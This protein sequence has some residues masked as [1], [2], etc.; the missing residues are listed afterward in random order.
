MKSIQPNKRLLTGQARPYAVIALAA[1]SVMALQLLEPGYYHLFMEDALYTPRYITQFKEAFGQGILYPRWMP[2]CF[3]G[4]G[5]PV[6]DYYSPLLYFL[7]ALLS[8]AGLS[9][10]MSVTSL[11]LLGLFVGGVFV[12][13]MIRDR[14]SDRAAL[15]AALL[16]ISLPT[17]V[18]D[19]YFI[20]TPAGRFSEVWMPMALFFTGRLVEGPFRRKYFAFAA[21]SYAALILS[22]ITTAYLF[23]PFLVAYGLFGVHPGYYKRSAARLALVIGTGL[24][25]SAVFFVP[26]IFESQYAQLGLLRSLD[27][28]SDWRKPILGLIDTPVSPDTRHLWSALRDSILVEAGGVAALLYILRRHKVFHLDRGASFFA[29]SLA[30]CI[31]MMSALSGLLWKHLPGFSLINFPSRYTVIYMLFLAALSG[32]VVD[33]YISWEGRPKA[34]G[35]AFLLILLCL[36]VYDVVLIKKSPPPVTETQALDNANQKDMF[37]Y[38]PKWASLPTCLKL[39]K[40]DPLFSSTDRF[41]ITVANWGY[42]DRRF[43]VDSPYGVR[44]R[45]K[46]FYFPGWK[47]WVDGR[48]TSISPEDKTGAI[49]LSIPAGTHSVQLKFVDTPPR[50]WGKAISLVTLLALVFPY[51]VVRRRRTV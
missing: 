40:E 37:E 10:A 50:A 33:A 15:I 44:L 18:F 28:F 11:K 30:V 7:S 9:Q 3:A 14:H 29:L 46:T 19:L 5:S 21:L 17:R 1:V 16:Y 36:V 26:V 2:E 41:S 48:E 8:L 23:T 42:V 31:F 35:A 51:G 27:V 49:V 20:N 38:L 39:K 34:I 43:T 6:F 25:L 13:H 24:C 47:A 45:V 32:P 22:H 12:F 4:Y